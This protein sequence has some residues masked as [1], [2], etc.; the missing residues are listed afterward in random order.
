[1]FLRDYELFAS[2]GELMIV[3]KYFTGFV[4]LAYIASHV[5]TY[6]VGNLIG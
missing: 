2:N 3:L 4:A 1:M 5:A 6:V